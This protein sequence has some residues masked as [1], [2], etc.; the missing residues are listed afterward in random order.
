LSKHFALLESAWN[1]LQNPYNNSHLSLG[2]SLHYLGKLKI[3]ILC[4]YSANME[5]CK[6]IEV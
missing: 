6:Q 3:Q 1:L 5:K 2:M 4:K